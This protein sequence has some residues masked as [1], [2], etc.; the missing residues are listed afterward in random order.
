M[1]RSIKVGRRP[2][3]LLCVAGIVLVFAGIHGVT[4]L[5]AL[6]QPVG[7]VLDPRLVTIS[8]RKDRN[9]NIH[10]SGW[11]DFPHSKGNVTVEVL[12]DGNSG[13]TSQE[14]MWQRAFI[15][16]QSQTATVVNGQNRY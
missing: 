12:A 6:I 1:M 2:L 13:D 8:V 10:F 4:V 3:L 15:L 14:N 5:F 9:Q 16:N 11:V 7:E